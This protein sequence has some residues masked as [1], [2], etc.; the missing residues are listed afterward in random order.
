MVE[1]GQATC[2]TLAILRTV[3]RKG[4]AFQVPV[5]QSEHQLP[6]WAHCHWFGGLQPSPSFAHWNG[7]NLVP[8]PNSGVGAK[9]SIVLAPTI[10]PLSPELHCPY[11]HTGP[12]CLLARDLSGC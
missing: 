1:D 12:R 5:M 2:S 4:V 3:P 11:R 10:A 8:T 9:T 6:H 7:A